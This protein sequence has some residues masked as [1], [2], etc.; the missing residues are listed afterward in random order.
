MNEARHA[1]Q[2]LNLRFKTVV[3]VRAVGLNARIHVLEESVIFA[4][5]GLPVTEER[6]HRQYALTAV[7]HE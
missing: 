6:R 5:A 1:A 7:S 3:L 2:G 4:H